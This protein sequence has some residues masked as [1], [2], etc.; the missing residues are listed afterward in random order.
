MVMFKTGPIKRT[1]RKN[2]GALSIPGYKPKKPKSIGIKN[3]LG[4]RKR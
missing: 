2:V 3:I 1:V 4:P